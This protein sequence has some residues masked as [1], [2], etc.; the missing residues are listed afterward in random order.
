VGKP[1]D[2]NVQF[3][4]PPCLKCSAK[5]VKILRLDRTRVHDGVMRTWAHPWADLRCW[6]CGFT[7]AVY[8]GE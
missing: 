2:L 7:W 4:A 3:K 8:I 5:W 1:G 6:G